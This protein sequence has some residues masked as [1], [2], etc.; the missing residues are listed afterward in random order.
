MIPTPTVGR[1]V[2]YVDHVTGKHFAAVIVHVWS[3]TCVNLAVFDSNG[4]LNPKT[5]VTLDEATAAN[6]TWHWPERT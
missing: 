4:N 5:S 3:D 1:V 2:H 6:F